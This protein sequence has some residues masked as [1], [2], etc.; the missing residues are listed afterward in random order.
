M[1]LSRHADEQ[2]AGAASGRAR[3]RG[4]RRRD[5]LALLAA[6]AGSRLAAAQGAVPLVG[7]LVATGLAPLDGVR[8]GLKALG[9]VEG[10]DYA[11]AFRSAD[12]NPRDLPRLARHLASLDP[13]TAETVMQLTA[14]LV[15]EG[16]L[17]TLMVTHNMHE[18]MR[19]GT[20]LVMMH[21]G[22]VI[23]DVAGDDKRRL[24]PATLVAKFYEA[25]GTELSVDRMLLAR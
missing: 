9:L 16:R 23:L 4:L 15:T 24:T 2:G 14:R 10:R 25:S 12:G 17:T 8:Q 5:C 19:W 22:R 11:I 1:R 21:A 13:R 6:I 3:R 7:V 20:R 18:A